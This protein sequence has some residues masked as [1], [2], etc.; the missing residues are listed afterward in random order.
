MFNRYVKGMHLSN[1]R[2]I[3]LDGLHE[4]NTI[5]NC[6]QGTP[7]L[8]LTRSDKVKSSI[9]LGS[10]YVPHRLMVTNLNSLD[11]GVSSSIKV[12]S[13]DMVELSI[14]DFLLLV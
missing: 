11:Y 4:N 9:H 14:N 13:N 10:P 7:S 2:S 6:T 12:K 8:N 3:D 1:K 5:E